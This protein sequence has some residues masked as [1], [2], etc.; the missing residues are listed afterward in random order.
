MAALMNLSSILLSSNTTCP[1]VLWHPLQ[2]RLKCQLAAASGQSRQHVSTGA[3]TYATGLHVCR[4]VRVWRFATGKL[5]RTYDESPEAAAQ[6]QREGPE[7]LRLEA[8]D[9]GRR[10]VG[11]KL[12]SDLGTSLQLR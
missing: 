9:F 5:R 3:C 10:Q 11:L 1:A 8:I 2:D 6:L 4:R 12:V 7:G